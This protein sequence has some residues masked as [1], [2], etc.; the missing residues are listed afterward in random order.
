MAER[1]VR[2]LDPMPFAVALVALLIGLM[3]ASFFAHLP[4]DRLIIA[5]YAEQFRSTGQLVF[6]RGENTLLMAAPLP[7]LAQALIGAD[8]LFALSMALG[9]ACLYY[10]AASAALTNASRLLVAG[11]FALAYPLWVGAGTGYPPMTGLALLGLLLAQQGRWRWA[12]LAFAA[13]ALCGTEVL[14]LIALMALYAAQQGK[15]W[16]FMLAFA[17]VCG[18]AFMALWLHYGFDVR[19]V[20]GLLTFRRSAPPAE[21]VLSLPFIALLLLAALPMWWQ[22]RHEQFIALL[23]A[24]IALYIGIWGGIFRLEGGFTYALIVPA[25]ALLAGRLFQRAP[26]VSVLGVGVAVGTSVVGLSVMMAPRALPPLFPVPEGTQ[27][28]A[29]PFKDLLFYQRWRLDQQLIALDGSL[30]PELRRMLER[31]DLHSALVRYAPDMLYLAH[32]EDDWRYTDAFTTLGYTPYQSERF[33]QRELPITGFTGRFFIMDQPFSPDLALR[34]AELTT[35]LGTGGD[36]LRVR[37]R[38]EVQ[39]PASRPITV[40]LRLGQAEQRTAFAANVFGAGTFDTYH[41]LRLPPDMPDGAVALRV[42][43][44]VNGGTLAEVEAARLTVRA[45]RD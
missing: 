14:V 13:A 39:R 33:F 15:A 18:A 28:V 7:M 37:L 45:M 43:A 10:L 20:E 17:A 42:R 8:A 19:F 23:G 44:I 11:I 9:A 32:A 26:I 22:A 2:A 21:D 41:A 16:R 12:G 35:E 29:V 27:R 3:A 1:S 34:Q 30:Q 25:A 24:W 38:W 4:D 31:G 5:R 6:N 36:L 40:Q